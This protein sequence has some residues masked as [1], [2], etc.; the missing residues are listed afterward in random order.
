MIPVPGSIRPQLK[1]SL[2]GGVVSDDGVLAS[3]VICL[4]R[5]AVRQPFRQGS[6]SCSCF[7]IGSPSGSPSAR[8]LGKSLRRRG[9]LSD[10]MPPNARKARGIY[11]KLIFKVTGMAMGSGQPAIPWN[12]DRS[13]PRAACSRAFG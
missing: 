10:M 9:G 3:Q 2:F 4:A 11:W 8:L 7:A 13:E 6:P 12:Y 5:R 1:Q